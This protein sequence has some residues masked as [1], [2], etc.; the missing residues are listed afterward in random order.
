[1]MKL[2]AKDRA[3]KKL[4]K[5]AEKRLEMLEKMG[6]TVDSLQIQEL[7]KHRPLI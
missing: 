4:E 3:M 1:M 7:K 2:N 6:E 5:E